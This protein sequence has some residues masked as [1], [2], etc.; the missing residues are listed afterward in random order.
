[1]PNQTV[2]RAAE[3]DVETDKLYSVLVVAGNIPRWAP[4][5]AD[6]IEHMVGTLHRVTKDGAIFN[7]EVCLHPSAGAVDIVREMAN[8][9]RGGAYLRVMPRPLGG[10]TVTITV[11]IGPGATDA[12]IA[13]TLEQELAAIIGLAQG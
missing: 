9:R 2:T 6:A 4:A 12:D 5:F 7:V 13:K 10:S 11:P 8:G 1:M 3:C